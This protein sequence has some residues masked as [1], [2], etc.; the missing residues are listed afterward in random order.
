MIVLLLV[1]LIVVAGL[2]VGWHM[3][4]DETSPRAAN[5]LFL[6]LAVFGFAWWLVSNMT[7][8]AGL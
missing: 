4:A 1:V 2:A 7:F 6:V 5:A 8:D 3:F